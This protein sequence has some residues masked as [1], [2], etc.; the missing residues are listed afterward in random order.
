MNLPIYLDYAATT[1][2][3]PRVAEKM[4]RFLTPSGIFGNPSSSH[5]FGVLAKKAV[6]EARMQVADAIHANPREIVFTSGATEANNLALK[7]AALLYQQK[8]KHI[9]TVKTEHPSVL[10]CCQQLE[11]EGF[12]VT[13]L[14]PDSGG[15]LSLDVLKKAFRADTFLVSIMHVNN[16]IGVIQDIEAIANLTAERSIL[17]HVDAAQSVG[18]VPLNVQKI[19][20]DLVSLCAHK[21]YGPKG[22]G[23][24]YVRAKPRVRVAALLHGGGHES[25]MRSGTLATHQM[26]GM[27]EAFALANDAAE[28]KRITEFKNIFWQALVKIPGIAMNGDD[29]HT[30]PHILNVRLPGMTADAFIQALPELAISKG[31]A[32]HARGTGPSLV[33]RALQLTTEEAGRSI[34]FSFGRFTKRAEIDDAISKIL[35]FIF[36]RLQSLSGK[37][38]I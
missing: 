24:L 20:V 22:I 12:F 25:G 17:L 28:K 4:M 1:P 21:V 6:D 3:D 15:L 8:G 33:L 13:Y 37:Q 27:G 19:P 34:R 23:A 9:I 31:S 2:V 18:K 35:S 32:C 26:V 38:F 14:S 29:A 11:K 16:E 10:D 30:V 36:N 5:S 7:G